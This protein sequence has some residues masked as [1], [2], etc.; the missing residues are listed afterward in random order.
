MKNISAKDAKNQFG[1]MIDDARL[2]P[3]VIQKHGRP[4]AV[5]CSVEEYERLIA[6]DGSN[7]RVSGS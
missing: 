3:V 1:K 4:V 7:H 2:E 5:V 6:L